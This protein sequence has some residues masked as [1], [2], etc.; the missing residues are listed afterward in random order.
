[1]RKACVVLLGLLLAVTLMA[2]ERGTADAGF[3]ETELKPSDGELSAQLAVEAAKA[4]A[5]HRTA[6]VQFYAD[7]CGPCRQLHESLS[8]PMMADAFK[9]TQ[10]L[11]LNYDI[12]EG[13]YAKA[14]FDPKCIPIF[15][16]IDETGK[17]TG[18]SIHAGAWAENIPTNM[19]PP[20]KTFF[21]KNAWK[22]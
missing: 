18:K 7:W 3:G 2:N 11:R 20:L 12:W 1:M 15:Y 19:A 10:M 22:P 4:K 13:K 21:T 17:P 5:R 9:G 16:A 14:S 8:N 6:Y